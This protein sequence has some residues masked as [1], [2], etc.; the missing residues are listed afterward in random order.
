PVQNIAARPSLPNAVGESV[1]DT[2][3]AISR[4]RG[5]DQFRDKGYYL[6]EQGRNG[7]LPRGVQMGTSDTG[8][9]EYSDSTPSGKYL[10][11]TPK[12]E[13]GSI[14][15]FI[16]ALGKEAMARNAPKLALQQ[17]AVKKGATLEKMLSD[18]S[19]NPGNTKL[20]DDF[21]AATGHT[22]QKDSVITI[23][24]EP[25]DAA[26]PELGMRK[27]PYIYTPSTKEVYRLEDLAAATNRPAANAG[28]SPVSV[29]TKT[30]HPDG[31]YAGPDGK[32][33]T[34]KGGQVVEV[35]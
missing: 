33:V 30:T 26:R 35:K 27:T 23:A 11:Q 20:R 31:V 14:G 9:T 15:G 16:G 4:L 8:T 7:P 2:S 12:Y 5:T 18:L 32:Q 13:I 17:Q 6:P 25:I 21:L 19:A 28:A 10:P 24:E 34:I 1:P 22:P 29:G 3:G